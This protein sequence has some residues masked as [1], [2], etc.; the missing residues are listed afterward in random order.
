[1]IVNLTFT[2]CLFFALEMTQ[3]ELYKKNLTPIMTLCGLRNDCCLSQMTL[4]DLHNDFMTS[5][6]LLL[7]SQFALIMTLYIFIIVLYDLHN[8]LD[9][10]HNELCD[11]HND[12]LP[13][14]CLC[15]HT[16]WFVCPWNK[17]VCFPRCVSWHWI[18]VPF[19]VTIYGTHNN[20]VCPYNDFFFS[21]PHDLRNK[22]QTQNIFTNT[23]AI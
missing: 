4:C 10:P 5:K 11:P 21:W 3:Y 7:S 14:Q 18:S 12:C 17:I 9:N 1:M 23:L 20:F 19:I 8:D 16:K 6:W 22:T 15:V 2:L 13:S